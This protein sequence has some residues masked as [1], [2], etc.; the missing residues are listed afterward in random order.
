MEALSKSGLFTSSIGK[1]QETYQRILRLSQRESTTGRQIGAV[2]TGLAPAG[3]IVI[4]DA[5]NNKPAN[6]DIRHRIRLGAGQEAGDVDIIEYN[7]NQYLV[8]YCTDYE[9]FICVVPF[10]MAATTRTPYIVHAS[11]HPDIFTHSAKRPVFRAL[12]FLTPQL[13]L[14]VRNKS[15]RSGADLLLLDVPTTPIQGT[16]VL[17]KTLHKNIKSVSCVAKATMPGPTPTHKIQHAIAV[18]GQ[19]I[20]LTILTLDHDPRSKNQSLSF[21]THSI[22]RNVHPMQMTALAFSR[23]KQPRD[24]SKA[25]PQYLKLASTSMCSTIKVHTFPLIPFPAYSKKQPSR[26]TLQSPATRNEQAQM[27]LSII[28]AVVMVALG[29]FFLQIF[30]EIRGATPEYLGAKSWFSKSTYDKPTLPYMLTD[31]P[32]IIDF[33]RSGNDQSDTPNTHEGLQEAVSDPLEQREILP[34]SDIFARRRIINADDP[35]AVPLFSGIEN[36]A[37]IVRDDEQ[38]L[39][40]EMHHDEEILSKEG[41]KWEDLDSG[42]QMA[43]KKRLVDARIW[44]VE[45]GEAI[46]KGRSLSYQPN[47]YD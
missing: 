21:R 11:P 26:Y 17:R 13:L 30:T 40:T 36:W 8:A 7:D 46:L 18:A 22:L 4:F 45:E 43:W 3:E 5:S 10:D 9:V 47:V 31:Q 42:E 32:R 28:V 39:S 29:A 41:K 35:D 20:S 12:R 14:L 16:I 34:L 24:P 25:L 2:A 23:F 1:K 15:N 33:P 38:G 27:G 37:V 6:G 44:A 19:D